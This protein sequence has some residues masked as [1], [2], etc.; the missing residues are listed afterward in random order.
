MVRNVNRYEP[1]AP[2]LG[3][4]IL[5]GCTWRPPTIHRGA[6]PTILGITDGATP[7]MDTTLTDI[8]VDIMEDN[9]AAISRS[10]D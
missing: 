9:M 4:A 1:W 10:F 5:R 3:L 6:F 8:T 2:A 7:R